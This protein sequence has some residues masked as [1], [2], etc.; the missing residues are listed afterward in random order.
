MANKIKFHKIFISEGHRVQESTN[1]A[2][3]V[4]PLGQTKLRDIGQSANLLRSRK[5]RP[6]HSRLMLVILPLNPSL[7][8]RLDLVER[9]IVPGRVN[10]PIRGREDIVGVSV[11]DVEHLR[12][13]LVHPVLL[14]APGIGVDRPLVDLAV[15]G[16][17]E[18][19]LTVWE[20]PETRDVVAE[21]M[22]LF[23]VGLVGQREVEGLHVVDDGSKT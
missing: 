14:D 4:L 19:F 13:A 22:A 1:C 8:A 12:H 9:L 17:R 3:L 20:P 10:V 5:R 16:R 2:S 6:L 21:V 11:A 15:S 23:E 18:E 7:A